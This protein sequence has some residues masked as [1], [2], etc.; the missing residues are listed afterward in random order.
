MCALAKHL[1][2]TKG[3]ISQWKLPGRRIPAEHCPVIQKFTGGA[4]RCET[5]RPDIDW[6]SVRT[7]PPT[8]RTRRPPTVLPTVPP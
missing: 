5:L 7:A 8:V 3:A 2:V 1:G 4:V 6:A